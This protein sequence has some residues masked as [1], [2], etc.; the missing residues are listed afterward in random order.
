MD[1]T[2][3]APLSAHIGT[4]LRVLRAERGISQQAL[5]DASG[6]PR[7]AIASVEAYE[8]RVGVDELPPLCIAL[9]CTLA[10]LLTGGPDAD[11]LRIDADG[12]RTVMQLKRSPDPYAARLTALEERVAALEAAR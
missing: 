10:D 6:I 3:E 12:T 7:H 2:T 9:D 4:R 1:T 5:A 8:R 11:V